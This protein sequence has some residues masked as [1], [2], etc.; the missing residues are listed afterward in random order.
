MSSWVSVVCVCGEVRIGA[1]RGEDE[2]AGAGEA[3]EVGAPRV[4]GEADHLARLELLLEGRQQVQVQER[5]RVGARRELLVQHVHLPR[6][7][8]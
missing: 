8:A 4:D 3:Q 7:I 5:L 6:P 2:E 1:G